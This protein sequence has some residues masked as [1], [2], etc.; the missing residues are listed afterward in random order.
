[1]IYLSAPPLLQIM[2]FP[3]FHYQVNKLFPYMIISLQYFSE[4][5]MVG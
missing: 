3:V 5:E 4:M 1:M 2:L